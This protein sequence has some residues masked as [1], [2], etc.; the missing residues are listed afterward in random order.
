[1]VV[2]TKLK[3]K[4]GK[5]MRERMIRIKGTRTERFYGNQE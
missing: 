2:V 5:G 4:N 3:N 1:M